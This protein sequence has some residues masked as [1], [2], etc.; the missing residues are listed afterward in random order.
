MK[1]SRLV[2]VIF[3]AVILSAPASAA[4]AP[5]GQHG[6]VLAQAKKQLA[7]VVTELR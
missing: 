2:I 1:L 5:D 7:K 6:D 4:V 3:L